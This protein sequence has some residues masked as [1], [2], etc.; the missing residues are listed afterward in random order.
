LS[1]NA[2]GNNAGL[3][4]YPNP[5]T[6]GNLNILI[7]SPLPETATITI[8]DMAGRTMAQYTTTTNTSTTLPLTI[9]A[10]LYLVKAATPSAIYTSKVVV[11]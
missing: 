5:T 3:S 6:T 9:P 2:L 11:Q 7:N 4:L 10:G 1:V 8:T